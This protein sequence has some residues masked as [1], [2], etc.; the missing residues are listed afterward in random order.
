MI[1]KTLLKIRISCLMRMLEL[2]L[3]SQGEKQADVVDEALQ[4]AYKLGLDD[5]LRGK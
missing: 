1:N 5:G 3:Q 4:Q 2:E